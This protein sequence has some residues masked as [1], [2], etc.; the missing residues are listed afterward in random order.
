MKVRAG[1]AAAGLATAG[2]LAPAA[3]GATSPLIAFACDTAG[4]FDLYVGRLDGT[5]VRQVT[6]GERSDTSPSWSPDG[7]HLVFWSALLGTS[8]LTVVDLADGGRR[9]LPVDAQPDSPHHLFPPAWAPDGRW[10]VFESNRDAPPSATQTDLYLIRPD[11]TDLRRLTLDEAL[12]AAPSWTP[13]SKAVLMSRQFGPSDVTRFPE[14]F[15][16]GLDGS[17]Q[18]LTTDEWHD[19]DATFAP[20][21]GAIAFMSN[22]G[23]GSDGTTFRI[24]VRDRRGT[25]RR[26]TPTP[27]GS[28]AF[29]PSWTPDGKAVVYA[30]DADGPLEPSLGYFGG[31][32]VRFDP[33]GLGPSQIRVVGVDGSGD[34]AVTDASSSCVT[35]DVFRR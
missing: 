22:R 19:W 32:D 24:H 29:T 31:T 1:L 15:V 20:R 6:S 28:S 33:P 10:I 16:H 34:R 8:Q 23:E 17:E 7:K 9:V 27:D 3:H 25:I 5:E 2:T 21:G 14:L 30:Y 26:I 18:R 11:G 4:T 12:T 13:D 35:P